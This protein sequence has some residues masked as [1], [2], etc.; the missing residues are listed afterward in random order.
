MTKLLLIP[1]RLFGEKGRPFTYDARGTGYERDEGVVSLSLKSLDAA[2]EYEDNIR[3]IIRNIDVN[4]EDKT[5]EITLSNCE[6]QINLIESIYR[7]TGLDSVDTN[8]V[9]TDG[10]DTAAIDPIEAEIISKIFTKHRLKTQPRV[11]ESTITNIEHLKAASE[12]AA[13]IKTIF[14]LETGKIASNINF[15]YPNKNSPISIPGKG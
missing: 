12:L 15:E 4:P 10:N 7:V 5:S 14:V 8:Y 11:F 6:A 2:T 3:A 13:M 9:K 1:L